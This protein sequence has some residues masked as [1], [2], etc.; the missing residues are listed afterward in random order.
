[1]SVGNLSFTPRPIEAVPLRAGDGPHV[2]I[3]LGMIQRITALRAYGAFSQ[4]RDWM[5]QLSHAYVVAISTRSA[6]KM[7]MTHFRTHLE[8]FVQVECKKCREAT[9]GE[10]MLREH[11]FPKLKS[12]REHANALVHHLDDPKN[13]GITDVNIEGIFEYCHHL[14]H[15]NI[16]ALFGTLP[17][18]VRELPLVKCKQC[19]RRS[20]DA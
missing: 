4:S 16:E 15:E 19:R 12:L 18:S 6:D 11:L 8:P 13:R 10:T 3:A 1:M 5:E 20:A 2:Q 17:E 9:L 7:L 14:F